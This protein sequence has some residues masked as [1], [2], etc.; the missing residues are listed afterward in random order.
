MNDW[1]VA[2]MSVDKAENTELDPARF[3]IRCKYV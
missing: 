1:F 2:W 3:I